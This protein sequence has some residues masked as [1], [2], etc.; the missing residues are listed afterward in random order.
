MDY[1]FRLEAGQ[2]AHKF[3]ATKH[4]KIGPRRSL[5]TTPGFLDAQTIKNVPL[6][7]NFLAW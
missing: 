5:P 4:T 6:A 3:M 7:P 2:G 1:S